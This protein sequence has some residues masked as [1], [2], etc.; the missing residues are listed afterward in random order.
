MNTIF[1]AFE[2]LEIDNGMKD[3]E[4]KIKYLVIWGKTAGIKT[5]HTILK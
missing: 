1:R 2:T 4:R 3:N 5:V